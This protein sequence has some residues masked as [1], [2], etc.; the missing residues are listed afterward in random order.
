[1]SAIFQLENDLVTLC[2]RHIDCIYKDGN[3][4]VLDESTRRWRQDNKGTIVKYLM[5][6]VIPK[7][8]TRTRRENIVK[9]IYK[10]LKEQY[11]DIEF[12]HNGY[13]LPFQNGVYDLI[14][15]EFRDTLVSDYITKYIP[16]DWSPP[17]KEK[18]DVIDA[19]VKTIFP[20]SRARHACLDSFTSGCF[21]VTPSQ[22]LILLNGKG[23]NGR[24]TL[25]MLHH[26]ALCDFCYVAPVLSSAAKL[27]KIQMNNM[28]GR[29]TILPMLSKKVKQ[30][31]VKNMLEA[32]KGTII[33][34]VT[35]P[36]KHDFDSTQEIVVIPFEITFTNDKTFEKRCPGTKCMENQ[37]IYRCPQWQDEYKEA[38]LQYLFNHMKN[39]N[40]DPTKITPCD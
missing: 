32:T 34:E 15:H 18:V 30:K 28:K 37:T 7:N 16:Y 29:R 38:W 36:K 35:D 12:D 24:E 33:A 23:N 26:V 11:H 40:F 17:P 20:D 14:S 9:T 39:T 6:D 25:K 10:G 2:L 31:R 8:T 22:S 1:M 3:Y 19:L 5:R 13:I 21:G 27:D 4:Y